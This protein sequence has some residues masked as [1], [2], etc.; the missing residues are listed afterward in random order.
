MVSIWGSAGRRTTPEMEFPSNGALPF[1]RMPALA[2][3]SVHAFARG[4]LCTSGSRACDG[5]S[6]YSRRASDN[7][8]RFGLL[9][10]FRYRIPT[11]RAR[12]ADLLAGR[13]AGGPGKCGRKNL[14]GN[15][16]VVV[17]SARCRGPSTGA[18]RSRSANWR[19][20]PILEVSRYLKLDRRSALSWRV[21]AVRSLPP[22]D[23]GRVRSVSARSIPCL[24][25]GAILDGGHNASMRCCSPV[26]TW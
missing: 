13:A 25:M 1:S 3:A 23:D 8:P 16:R 4:Q 2:L 26:P 17:V 6:L 15:C 22:G 21:E 12:E 5:F 11:G 14:G 20:R 24:P 18:P 7:L 9:Q 19:R 10:G